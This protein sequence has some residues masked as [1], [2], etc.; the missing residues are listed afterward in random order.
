VRTSKIHAKL[1]IGRIARLAFE[2][3][4]LRNGCCA[5]AAALMSQAPLKEAELEECAHLDDALAKAQRQLKSAV[6]DVMFARLH[7]RSKKA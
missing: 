7:R 5:V 3:D 4:A 1:P 6:K 2:M